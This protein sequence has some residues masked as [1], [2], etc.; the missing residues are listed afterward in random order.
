M[1]VK[2]RILHI[3]SYF[4][5]V[6]Q[7]AENWDLNCYGYFFIWVV[8]IYDPPLSMIFLFGS[9]VQNMTNTY[10]KENTKTSSKQI[11]IQKNTNDLNHLPSIEH[12]KSFGLEGAKFKVETEVMISLQLQWNRG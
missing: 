9:R 12:D 5:S 3:C 6:I 1:F 2:T 11:Q 8:W 4:L 10:T 7:V